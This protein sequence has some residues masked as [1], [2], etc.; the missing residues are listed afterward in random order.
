MPDNGGD[1]LL[2]EAYFH[3]VNKHLPPP[4]LDQTVW[5]VMRFAR[6]EQ[7]IENRALWFARFDEMEDKAECRVPVKNLK[8]SIEA[9]LSAG[10][11]LHMAHAA[12]MRVLAGQ[13]FFQRVE[14]E[15]PLNLISCWYLGEELSD[16]MWRAYG[17]SSGSVA[18]RSRGDEVGE[19]LSR[20]GGKE[21]F[22]SPIAY[23]DHEQQELPIGHFLG[24]FFAK[25]RKYAFESELRYLIHLGAEAP[26]GDY[27]PAELPRLIREVRVNCNDGFDAQRV[28]S[29]IAVTGAEVELVEVRPSI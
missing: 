7:L 17:S 13:A 24:P 14:T 9:L 29:L 4:D 10:I 21:C 2:I 26:K 15:K 12:N 11:P 23:L 8:P 18:I 22:A 25:M 19:A 27:V 20:A 28:Q 6:F 1:P 5:K 3:R 16:E